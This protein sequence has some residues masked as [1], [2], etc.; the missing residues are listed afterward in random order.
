M[1]HSVRCLKAVLWGL[2]M[3]TMGCAGF[4]LFLWMIG[5]ELNWGGVHGLL[6]GTYVGLAWHAE[7][8][9]ARL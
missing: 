6:T 3:A 9:K 4:A 7:S 8:R 5:D 1:S 2:F